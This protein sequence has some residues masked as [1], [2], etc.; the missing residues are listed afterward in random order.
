MTYSFGKLNS[1]RSE[2]PGNVLIVFAKRVGMF[3]TDRGRRSRPALEVN[4][5]TRTR[6]APNFTAS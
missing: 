4:T 1:T 3:T 5:H 2:S 6:T